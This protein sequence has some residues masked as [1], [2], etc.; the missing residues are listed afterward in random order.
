M[1]TSVAISILGGSSTVVASYLARGRTSNEP[2]ASRNR[3][4]SLNHFLREIRGFQL[5]HGYSTGNEF[6]DRI[7]G[8]RL[9]LEQMLGNRPGSLAIHPSEV[10]GPNSGQVSEKG[11]GATNPV[12][13]FSNTFNGVG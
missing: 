11:V 6:D 9:G 13:G 8:Y 10:V 7:K 2:E 1:Q 4:I 5:D 12:Q 3:A